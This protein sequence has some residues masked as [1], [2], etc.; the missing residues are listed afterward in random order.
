MLANFVDKLLGLLRLFHALKLHKADE[1]GP[2]TVG[3]AELVSI[4]KACVKTL[5]DDSEGSDF[6]LT[7]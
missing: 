4:L 6:N 2:V 3:G 1:F 7:K 5:D